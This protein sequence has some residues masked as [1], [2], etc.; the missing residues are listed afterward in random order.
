MAQLGA[1]I[2]GSAPAQFA[3]LLKDDLARW[4]RVIRTAHVKLD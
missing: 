4:A 1:D 2:V 3:A